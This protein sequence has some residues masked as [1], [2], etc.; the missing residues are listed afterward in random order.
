MKGGFEMRVHIGWIFVLG[1]ALSALL[2]SQEKTAQQN[3]ITVGYQLIPAPVTLPTAQGNAYEEHRVFLLDSSSGNVWE[4]LPERVDK[5]HK[6]F[7]A[8]FQSVPV[9]STYPPTRR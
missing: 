1:L 6:Y 7:P 8:S 2:Y 5:E 4:Y 3:A 9:V